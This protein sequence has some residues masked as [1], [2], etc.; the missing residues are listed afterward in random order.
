MDFLDMRTVIFSY[1]I[2]NFICMILMTILW[3]QNRRKFA[4]L[5]LWLADF[6]AQFLA[7][8]LILLRGLV[9]DFLSMT[10]S[11]ALVVG[12]TILLYIGL[13]QFT[14]KRSSQIH[15]FILLGV[16]LVSSHLSVVG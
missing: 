14:G 3:N 7:M 8:V 13:E 12:G 2:S 9:P 5:E 1:T 4:G 15:N 10:V 6:V 11:N 16:F